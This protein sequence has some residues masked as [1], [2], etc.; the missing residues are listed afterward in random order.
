MTGQDK[1]RKEKAGWI[2]RRRKIIRKQGE[3]V[4]R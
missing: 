1:N 2:S 3:E 4:D